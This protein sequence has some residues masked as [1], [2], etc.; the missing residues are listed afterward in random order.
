MK[1]L[2]LTL[3]VVSMFILGCGDPQDPITPRTISFDGDITAELDAGGIESLLGE[4][5]LAQKTTPLYSY[6]VEAAS[7]SQYRRDEDGELLF[8]QYYIYLQYDG[9]ITAGHQDIKILDVYTE[10]NPTNV[11]AFIIDTDTFR[12]FSRYPTKIKANSTANFRFWDAYEC[13]GAM[14]EGYTFELV[15]EAKVNE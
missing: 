2:N 10:F 8:D 11:G 4:I 1:K 5:V 9:T 3:C 12:P 13:N 15:V 6:T 7:G 14:L